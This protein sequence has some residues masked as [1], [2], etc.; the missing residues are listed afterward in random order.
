MKILNLFSGSGGNRRLWNESITAVEIDERI[1]QVYQ[2]EFKNDV[3]I[4]GDAYDYLFKN[5]QQFDF[6]WASP[7]CITH[8]RARRIPSFPDLRLY[9]IIL[10]LKLYFK[11]YWVV[12]NVI[13]RYTPLIPGRIFDRHMIWSNFYIGNYHEKKKFKISALSGT[14]LKHKMKR[15]EVSPQLG[16]HIINH[17]PNLYKAQQLNVFIS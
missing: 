2:E 5:F 13:P 17:V 14:N 3:V 15:N 6:I 4:I 16:L 8:S 1:A 10:F 7:P 11:G 12:E 9:E